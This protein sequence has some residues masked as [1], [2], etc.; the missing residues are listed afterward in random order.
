MWDK[1]EPYV[2]AKCDWQVFEPNTRSGVCAFFLPNKDKSSASN[3]RGRHESP[4]PLSSGHRSRAQIDTASWAARSTAGTSR[5]PPIQSMGNTHLLVKG[6]N[7][8]DL[9]TGNTS[10][11]SSWLC[12]IVLGYGADGC[13]RCCSDE[14]RATTE[15]DHTDSDKKLER[16]LPLPRLVFMI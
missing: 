1:L 3:H 7:G 5:A 12:A 9:W 10:P 6:N 8:Q 2:F 14:V 13:V 11:F 4:V 16:C 15:W